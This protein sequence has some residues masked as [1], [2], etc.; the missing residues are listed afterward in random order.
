[1]SDSLLVLSGE[2]ILLGFVYI[3]Y[4]PVGFLSVRVLFP[5]L[6][7]MSKRLASGMLA[8][9]ILV[10]IMWL[11][12]QRL[13]SPE[14][15]L[16]A[17]QHE[18]NI[19][20]ALASAQLALVS[21]VALL[22]ALLGNRQPA[23]KRLYWA[24]V[25]AVFLF[26]AMDEFN[27]YHEWITGWE[28]FYIV[29]G[30]VLVA[31]TTLVAIYSSRRTMIW[32]GCMLAG[33]AMSAS[34][35]IMLE[36]LKHET[37]CWSWRFARLDNC[38]LY[39][40]FEEPLEFLG[41]WIVLVAVLG[42]FS[43]EVPR[44]R[45]FVRRAM[46]VLPMLWILMLATILA[47][48]YLELEVMSL[49][50]SIQFES[51]VHLYGY[52]IENGERFSLRLY[53]S[54]RRNDY[55]NLG[56]SV[57]LVDQASGDSVASHNQHADRQVALLRYPNYKGVYRQ[58]IEIPIPSGI[59]V[60]R[61][62]WIILTIWRKLDD[63]YVPQ[64][65]TIS[66]HELLSDAQVV[67]GEL[68]L[69]DDAP[70]PATAPLARFDNGF[71]LGA[72]ELPNVARA[73]ENLVISFDWRSDDNGSED[74]AQFLHLRHAESG[75]WFVY[76][77]EPLGPR[78]PTRLWYRGLA[79]SETWRVPLPADL[80]PGQYSV[81]TGIYRTRDQERVPARDLDGSPFIDAR[82]PLGSLIIEAS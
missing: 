67:L 32:F 12:L 11:G 31:A 43:H 47:F 21:G 77:Q 7:P 10:I 23:W 2:S 3:L 16:W 19:P 4:F 50:A 24:G 52:R 80:A 42:L 55:F 14:T 48:D 1:M 66:D 17:L 78:L 75:A 64:K 82:V 81:F 69:P 61:A 33:L 34:G 62:Y 37:L 53:P 18:A 35:G 40:H 5:R 56:Y 46:Y 36:Q 25:F 68:V 15:F 70:T 44:T 73:G 54:V 13:S 58:Q 28:R 9:Q 51:R 45:R 65:I 6:S 22:T 60:N 74:H 59:P 79:D 27:M 57:H 41:I 30:A 72:A 20:T 71:S 8:A 38:L 29:L 49:P 76:D 26:L 63:K 39:S